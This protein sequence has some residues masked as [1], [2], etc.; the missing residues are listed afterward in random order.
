MGS[1]SVS[2]SQD[3]VN[4]AIGRVYLDGSFNNYSS[5]KSQEDDKEPEPTH[6]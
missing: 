5:S 6:L 3:G 1:N 2:E 4:L